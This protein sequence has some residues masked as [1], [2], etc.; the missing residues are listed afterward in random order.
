MLRVH[1]RKPMPLESIDPD[2]MSA[3]EALEVL[4]KHMRPMLERDLRG[5]LSSDPMAA[6]DIHVQLTAV[7]IA[8]DCITKRM[9]HR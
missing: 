3:A 7:A 1:E 9:G 8:C 5:A 6:H 4:D 2:N